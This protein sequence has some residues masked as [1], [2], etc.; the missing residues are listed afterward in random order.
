MGGIVQAVGGILDTILGGGDAP[1][2]PTAPTP[3][4]TPPTVMPTPDDK[5]SMEA[6]RR[7]A[8]ALTARKGRQ[9]TVLDTTQSTDLL[10]G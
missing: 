9:S 7:Q 10:G 1:A 8:A 5:A 2:Q 3:T 4:V 6:K